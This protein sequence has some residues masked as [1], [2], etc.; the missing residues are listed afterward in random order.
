MIRFVEANMNEIEVD[1]KLRRAIRATQT[2]YF[3][4]GR[5]TQDLIWE[6]YPFPATLGLGSQRAWL[7]LSR[8]RQR[9]KDSV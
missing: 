7:S 6:Q 9:T 8:P 5:M 2:G 1:E 4:V 3:K